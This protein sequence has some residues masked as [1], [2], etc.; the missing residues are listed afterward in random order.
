[1][2]PVGTRSQDMDARRA[3]DEVHFR[4]AP[5]A[6]LALY[7]LATEEIT[8]RP[9]SATVVTDVA[10]PPPGSATDT[11]A[12]TPGHGKSNVAV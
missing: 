5:P 3:C 12:L 1:M 10:A 11:K 4:M 9:Q 6:A 2:E 7:V 8:V